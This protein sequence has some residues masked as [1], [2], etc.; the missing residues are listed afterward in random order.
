MVT[1]E[2]PT[3]DALAQLLCDAVLTECN[4]VATHGDTLRV[5]AAIMPAIVAE[6]RERCAAVCEAEM[7]DEDDTNDP[8]DVYNMACRQCADAIRGADA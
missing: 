3:R 6:E 7:V 8:E 1:H 5:L 2:P 4:V